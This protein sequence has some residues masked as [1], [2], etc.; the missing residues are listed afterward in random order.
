MGEFHTFMYAHETLVMSVYWSFMAFWLGFA[1][2]D[3]IAWRDQ[4][5]RMRAYLELRKPLTGV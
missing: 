5:R 2:R 4:Q 3:Y 1:L